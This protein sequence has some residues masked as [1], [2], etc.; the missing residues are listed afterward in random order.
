MKKFKTPKKVRDYRKR[1]YYEH[2]E[3]EIRKNKKRNKKYAKKLAAQQEL[4]CRTLRGRFR[5]LRSRAKQLGVI[6]SI[7]FE[8]YSRLITDAQCYYCGGKLPSKGAG[9]DRIV[10]QK[11]YTINNVRPCCKMCNVAKNS[12][13]EQQFEEWATRLGINWAIKRLLEG[14]TYDP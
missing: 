1:W 14:K 5:V 6:C 3:N 10:P 9:L 13:S 8:E 12:F 11:G 4:Y 7:S 2:Q